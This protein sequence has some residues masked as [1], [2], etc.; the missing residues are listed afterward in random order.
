MTYIT[1]S[2][3]RA[4]STA[5]EPP[6]PRAPRP[7]WLRRWSAALTATLTVIVMLL[8]VGTPVLDIA[9]YAAYVLWCLVLP[10]T[11]VYRVLRRHR[12]SLVDDLALGLALGL[13]L[14]VAAWALFSLV[15]A[16]GLL[17]SLIHISE[18]TRPY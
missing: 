1:R 10:G 12:H 15:G 11:L 17:L 5:V 13:A 8:A 6:A 16:Q 14:E 7:G 3:L 18:P 9:R 4:S 2:P